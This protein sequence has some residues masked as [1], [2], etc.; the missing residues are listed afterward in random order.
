MNKDDKHTQNTIYKPINHIE[1]SQTQ[2]TQ[3]Y[4]TQHNTNT[5]QN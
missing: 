4:K 5:K 2:Q 3:Q 1:K